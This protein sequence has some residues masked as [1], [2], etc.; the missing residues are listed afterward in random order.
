MVDLPAGTVYVKTAQGNDEIATRRHG[1]GLRVRQ[2]LILIDGRRSVADLARMVSETELRAHLPM[3]RDQGFVALAGAMPAGPAPAGGGPIAGGIGFVARGDVPMGGLPIGAQA[4]APAAASAAASAAGAGVGA[5][6]GAGA[7]ASVGAGAGAGSAAGA[8]MGSGSAAT[9]SA[10][11]V[12]TPAAPA[13]P[14][15]PPQRRDL[16][17]V[18]RLLV[19]QLVDALGPHADDMAVRIERCRSVDEIRQLMTTIASLVEAIRG[20]AAMVAF[21]QRVGPL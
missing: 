4:G 7:G 13:A 3:L 19:R 18:R 11:P 10:A 1:L 9:H 5:G 16:E 14:A 17:T 20:R 12:Q 6:M 2:L 15:E 21:V 8:G